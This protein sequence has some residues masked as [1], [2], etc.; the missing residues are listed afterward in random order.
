MLTR[1]IDFQPVLAPAANAG[2]AEQASAV[3]FLVGTQK[4]REAPFFSFSAQMGASQQTVTP[5]PMITP[6]NFLSGVVIQI[7]S[8][9]GV[10]GTANAL[11]NDG[12]LAV[13]NSISLTDTG[14]G[15]ILYPMSL[16]TY[17]MAQK[18]LRPW[19]GDPIK[20]ANFSN[21]INPTL[22]FRFGI[23]VRDTLAVLANTD[24]RAQY[25]L[26]LVLAPFASL[27]TGAANNTAPTVTVK[28][29]IDAWA[30]PD[31][32]DLTGRPIVP[33][34]PGLST[35]RYLMHE[36]DVLNSGN[37]T[38]RFTLTGNEIRGLLLIFRDTN[39]NRVDLTDANA[40]NMRFRLDNRVLWVMTPS[41]IVEEMAAFYA[42]YFGGGTSGTGFSGGSGAFTGS[43]VAAGF[44]RETG[45]YAIPRFRDPGNLGGEYWL[46]TVE[47]SLLQIEFNGGDGATTLEVVYD[48]LAVSGILDPELEG[49]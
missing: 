28:G 26:N 35:S 8:A 44:N 38:I 11:T 4:Y 9:S 45:V 6:G 3:P 15:E 48:Q 18:Y 22:T 46:Q 14:G 21:S 19:L 1:L 24:A 25:R 27:A 33:V 17:V 32:V 49:I 20:R 23:E 43:T 29:Y 36:T 40:G 7:T 39:G 10:L 37:N 12:T 42:Q 2:D 41:Q 47:Q 5:T 13:L 31:A 34:P 16:F 30:Q